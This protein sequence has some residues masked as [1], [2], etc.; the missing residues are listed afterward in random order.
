METRLIT[1]IRR[2]RQFSKINLVARLWILSSLTMSSMDCGAQ[3][4]LAYSKCGLTRARYGVCLTSVLSMNLV[5]LFKYQRSLLAR[6][7]CS[8][9]CLYHVRSLLI[10]TPRSISAANNSSAVLLSLQEDKIGFVFLVMCCAL[11]LASLK[12]RPDD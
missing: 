5:F 11:H 4:W 6:E 9:N 7:D 2:I 10:H 3:I 8:F 12:R 1:Y